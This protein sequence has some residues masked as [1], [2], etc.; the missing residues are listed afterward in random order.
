MSRIQDALGK[1]FGA[2]TA[3]IVIP[4]YIGFPL[5]ELYWLWMAIKLGSFWMFVLGLAGPTII[6][7]APVGLW[8]LIFGIPAWVVHVWGP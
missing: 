7:A 2:A 3:F 6:F 5:G 8:S 1:I 4:L